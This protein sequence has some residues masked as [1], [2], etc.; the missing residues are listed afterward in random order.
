LTGTLTFPESVS[1]IGN[2][3][4]HG[5]SGIIELNLENFTGTYGDI[6]LKGCTSL[7]TVYIS[8]KTTH[9]KTG[10]NTEG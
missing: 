4:F 6:F 1:T 2:Q 7:Q 5:C 10:S 9:V 8:T 3:A